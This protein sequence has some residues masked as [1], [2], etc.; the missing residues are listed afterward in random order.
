[1]NAT[2]SSPSSLRGAAGNAGLLE[3]VFGEPNA[4]WMREMRQSARLGRTPWILFAVT[5]ATALLMSAIGG[6]AA[7]KNSSP[8]SLGSALFQV[9]FSIGFFVVVVVGPAVAANSIASEREGKTWEAVLLTGLT[10]KDIARGKFFAAYTTIALYIVMLAPVGALSFLF[11][12]VTALEVVVAFLFLF[13]LAGL[14]VAFGLAV[15]SFMS[16]LRGAIV[17]TLILAICIGPAA[18]ST[19]GFGCSFA[20]HSLWREVPEAFPIWL[21]LAYSR[22]PFGVDYIL[23]LVALPLL[24][25]LI[26]AWFLYETTIANLTGHGD[27]RS[28]GLKRWFALSTPLLAIAAALPGVAASDARGHAMLSVFAHTCFF[29]HLTFCALLFSAEP[30]GPSRRVRIHWLRSGAGALRRFVGPG[31]TKTMVLVLLLGLIGM[32][33]IAVVHVGLI[34]LHGSVGSK[35]VALEQMFVFGFYAT[36]FFVF[37]VGLV[38]WLRAR[39]IHHNPWTPR[40]IASAVFFVVAAAPWVVALIGGALS[41]RHGEE[42]LVVAAPSPFYAYMMVSYV[43]R[44]TADAI[45]VVVAGLGSAVV[46]GALGFLFLFL[47]SRRCARTVAEQDAAVAQTEAALAAEDEQLARAAAGAAAPAAPSEAGA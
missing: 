45:P 13:I 42:W 11:G 14:S 46:W 25:L 2:H 31:L 41:D 39:N 27:D 19:F 47:A 18:Y 30:A 15:S 26:P 23:L 24:L 28:S 20:V 9:F 33:G 34:H 29:L 35:D 16:S 4:I 44:A 10:P 6:I 17:V 7:S 43:D 12:G 37:M 22:A 21:P 3:R 38:A 5:L 32:A 1:M 36:L 40:L 8:A